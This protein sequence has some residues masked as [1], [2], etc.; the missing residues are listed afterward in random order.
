MKEVA[1]SL[2]FRLL[3][4]V[5]ALAAG[6]M[7]MGPFG[8]VFFSPIAGI[9]LARPLLDKMA[10]V[11]YGARASALQE[12]QGKYYAFRGVRFD[13]HEDEQ[14][15]LWLK[16]ADVRTLLPAFPRDG[17]LLKVCDSGLMPDRTE[18]QGMRVRADTLDRLLSTSRQLETIKFRNWLQKEVIFPA[19]QKAERNIHSPGQ[20]TQPKKA[21]ETDHHALGGGDYHPP[22][23]AG[24]GD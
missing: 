17:V 8:L 20:R 14:R 13:V 22:S 16:T 7:I 9:C 10:G 5:A 2:R 15:Q 18:E 23:D 21:G 4:A 24:D 12:F 1:I 11:Y 6:W 19:R 3:L